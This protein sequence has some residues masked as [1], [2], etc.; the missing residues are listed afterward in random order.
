M[1]TRKVVFHVT[2]FKVAVVMGSKGAPESACKT[3]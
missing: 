1:A 2:Y 3:T